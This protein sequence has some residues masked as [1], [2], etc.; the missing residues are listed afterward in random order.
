MPEQQGLLPADEPERIA[1]QARADAERIRAAY[2]RRG[3]RQA[4][5]G[6]AKP[7]QVRAYLE[8]LDAILEEAKGK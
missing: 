5:P 4:I 1:A 7:A 8:A 2:R 3:R 6:E